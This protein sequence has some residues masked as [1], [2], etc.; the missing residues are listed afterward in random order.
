MD[1]STPIASPNSSSVSGLRKAT[2]VAGVAALVASFILLFGYYSVS[3][4]VDTLGGVFVALVAVPAIVICE[5][6]GFGALGAFF[7]KNAG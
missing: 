4:G 3:A 7:A 5:N 6:L 1:Q 2:I